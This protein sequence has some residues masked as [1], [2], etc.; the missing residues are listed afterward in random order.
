MTE[1]EKFTDCCPRCRAARA[2][3]GITADGDDWVTALYL[4]PDCDRTWTCG[5]GIGRM[6][7]LLMPTVNAWDA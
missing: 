4:C 6:R 7:G 5:W 2:P 1:A 3:H